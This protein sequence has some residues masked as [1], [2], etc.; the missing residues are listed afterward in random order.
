MKRILRVLNAIEVT[1]LVAVLAFLIGGTFAGVIMR[2][3][4]NHPLVW[5]EEIQ[6]ASMVWIAFLGA[7]LA[8]RL[9]GHVAIEIVV[10]YLPRQARAVAEVLIGV[11]IYAVLAYLL[12]RSLGFIEMF[13]ATDRRTPILGI[14]YAVVYGIAPVSVVLMAASYTAT[15]FVDRL[16]ELFDGNAEGAV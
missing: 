2:Y 3:M 7:S 14:P 5:L 16:K 15:E 4:V 10:D 8:F 13:V 1:I 11:V 9:K 12:V 6:L